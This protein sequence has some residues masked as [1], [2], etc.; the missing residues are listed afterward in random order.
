MMLVGANNEPISLLPSKVFHWANDREFSDPYGHSDLRAAYRSWWAKKFIIQFWNV[1]LERMGA[2]MTAIKYPQGS[3]DELKTN[4]KN[5][6]AGLSSKTEL[7][8]PEGVE[9]ELIEATRAGTAGYGEALQYQDKEIARACLMV[10][11]LGASGTEVKR[12]SDSQARIHLR[13][14]YK[15]ADETGAS[16]LEVFQKQIVEPLVD[17]NF[18]VE[19]YP[20]I[21]WQDYGEFE[22]QEI[23]DEVRLLHAAGILELDGEDVNFVRSILGLP[24]RDEGDEDSVVRPPEPPPPGNANAPPP[25]ASQGNTRASKGPANSTTK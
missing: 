20:T 7:L 12:G 14:L 17:F 21:F 18:T 4:L 3:N 9:I 15:M 24:L 11:L 23:A 8:I 16:V 5:I 19:S 22:A 13:T 1:F 10:A 2:P 6:L 25:A